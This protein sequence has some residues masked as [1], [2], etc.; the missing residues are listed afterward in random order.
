L[1]F[2]SSPPAIAD[3]TDHASFPTYW[4]V[5]IGCGRDPRRLLRSLDVTQTAADPRVI[6]QT[7]AKNLT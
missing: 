4:N 6:E 2:A 3:K 1:Q 5:K 7:M